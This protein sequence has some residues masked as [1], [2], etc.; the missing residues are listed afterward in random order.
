MARVALLVLVMTLA[1]PAAIAQATASSTAGDAT[2]NF[3]ESST[4][5]VYGLRGPLSATNTIGGRIYGPYADFFGRTRSQ[6][7][8][9]TTTWT[10]PSGYT[11]RIHQRSLPAFQQARA[12]IVNSGA[13]YRV[14]SGAAWVWRN[15]SGSRQMS[16]HAVGNAIDINPGQNPYT[17]GNLVTN[18]P[19]SYVAAWTDAGFCWGGS[20]R[21]NKDAMHF[22]WEGPANVAGAGAR[23]APYPP[24]TAAAG[25]MTLVLD[26]PVAIPGSDLY[27]VADR[28]RHGA[29]DLYGLVEMDGDWQVQVAGAGSDYGIVGI[30]RTSGATASGVPVFADADGDG[31]A[32]LWVFNTSGTIKADVYLDGARF[33]SVGRHVVTGAGWG[34]GTELGLAVFDSVDWLPDLFVI[35][36]TT[37]RVDVYSSS[38]GYQDRIHTSVLPV[39]I[40]S[41]QIV[42]AD[43]GTPTDGTADIWL[44]GSGTGARVRIVRYSSLGYQGAVETLVTAMSV[45]SGASVLPGDYDGDGRI[46]LHVVSGGR[47]RVWLGGVPDRPLANLDDWFKPDGPV[48]FDAGPICAGVCDSIG[49]ADPGGRWRLAREP[50]WGPEETEFFYGNPGDQPFMGDWDCDGV[51]TPGLYRRGDGYV[52]L[53]NSNTQGIADIA[54]FFGNPGD[55]PLAGDF[56][57]DGC[58]TV[59]IYRPSEARFYVINEL[60]SAGGGLGAAEF[61]FFF[62]DFGDQPFVGDFDGDGS[63]EVGL[64]R[65]TTGRVYYRNTLTTGVADRDFVYGDPGDHLVAGDWDGDGVDTPAIYR[66]SDGNWYLRL[67]NSPGWANHVIPFGLGDRGYLPVVGKTQ[68]GPA[69]FTL[70]C[71]S[72]GE[73]GAL[74]P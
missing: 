12:N 20:W 3:T 71:E 27:A 9:S 35:D 65:V 16:Q 48:T 52:Y 49:Y 56:D 45:P 70:L 55:L 15:I 43:R 11:F 26:A 30:R 2:P 62:G 37:G 4:C 39:P 47:I 10:E 31:R 51:D 36:R 7:E 53:R 69:A 17:N 38:S 5:G 66:P 1:T 42:L 24:L 50:A 40:G 59:S 46:D 67:S 74:E 32:D 29:D 14:H 25:F 21:F 73:D 18:L 28:R 44:V 68:L 54:F 23:L 64:H 6:V 63:D 58:D 72:C 33:R 8:A 60:G 13:G 41:D 34:A 19:A 57:G 61:S 22:T